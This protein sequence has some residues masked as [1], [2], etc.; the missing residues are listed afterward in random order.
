MQGL[1]LSSFFYG[2]ITTQLA[3]GYLASR[4]GGHLVFACGIGVTAVLT[5][6]SP[7]AANLNVY[8]LVAVRIL[9]GV[10]EGVTFPCIHAIWANWAPPLERSRMASIVS[11]HSSAEDDSQKPLSNCRRSL[12]TT[13]E[14]LSV[15]H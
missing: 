12:E 7:L 9:E 6:F 8:A 14:Q 13:Q 2:Y 10:F 5:L 11:I 4:I 3:G 15:C 1:L